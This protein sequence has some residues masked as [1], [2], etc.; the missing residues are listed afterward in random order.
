MTN[1]KKKICLIG[2][3]CG[4][5]KGQGG[6]ATYI[7]HT[8]KGF[9][10]LG[11]EVHTIFLHGSDLHDPEITCWKIKDNYSIFK[12]SK[13]IDEVLSQIK[14]D[15]VEVTDFIG[16]ASYTLAKRAL[17]GLD[18]SC[19]FITNN[20]TGIREVW[21]WGTAL[22]FMECAPPWMIEMYQYERA[23]SILSDANFSTSNF[24]SNYLSALHD[25]KVKTCP[26]Y[27]PL[28]E[29]TIPPVRDSNG[30][31]EILSLGRFELRK[32]QELL[33]LA[34]CELMS[35]GCNLHVTL[36]GNSG[37]D[38]YD[39]RDYMDTCYGLIPLELK[40]NFSF[41]DFIPYKE[42][43]KQYKNYD[44]FV[45]PSPY[46]NFPNTAL[47]AI[48]YGLIVAGSKTSGIADMSGPAAEKLCFEKNSVDSI[49]QMLTEFSNMS[50]EEK[51]DIRKVQR[52]SLKSLV[53]FE[54]AIVAR[55]SQYES[56]EIKSTNVRPLLEKCLFVTMKDDARLEY[57]FLGDKKI[58]IDSNEAYQFVDAA[59]YMIILPSDNLDDAITEKN[60]LPEKNVIS[61][62]S[63]DHPYGTVLDINK[64]RKAFSQLTI[65]VADV[66]ISKHVKASRL[67]A[68]ILFSCKDV[69]FFRE[70]STRVE[71]G[72]G[73][74]LMYELDLL[75]YKYN[76]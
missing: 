49:K 63:Y 42:L 64:S 12:N 10:R 1:A 17:E 70:D 11:Y 4:Y 6:V 65:N 41:Y 26:S 44:L 22:D 76:G 8:A 60:Y 75:R 43:Q 33:I 71:K 62:F 61:A 19:R 3:E 59:E 15:F 39:R 30:S 28:A 37:D 27:Y 18:Y 67:I 66:S 48:N 45:I 68:E 47:E 74:D 16:L 21:E 56:I 25:T 34:A 73:I 2:H 72:I 23:Q 69:V 20:H 13:A 57:M 53:S 46:E 5:Y 36:I 9:S 32:K 51:E 55:A 24:L 38:F 50:R 58:H 35:E 29:Q 54:S 31:F 7:E 40:K 14:P 52:E